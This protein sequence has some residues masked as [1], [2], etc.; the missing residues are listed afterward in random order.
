[1]EKKARIDPN[2]VPNP[3]RPKYYRLPRYFEDRIDAIYCDEFLIPKRYC[4]PKHLEQITTKEAR[5]EGIIFHHA[6]GWVDRFLSRHSL[7][8]RKFHMARRAPVNDSVI[9]HFLNSYETAIHN[10]PDDFIINV[11]ETSWRLLNNR[12]VTITK[13]G[14][15]GVQCFFDGGEKD[16]LTVI[17]G[18]TRSGK[19]L[20]PWV[21]CKG[22]TPRCMNKFLKS[23]ILRQYHQQEALFISFSETGWTTND[24]AIRYLKWLKNEYAKGNPVFLIWDCYASHRSEETK[25]QAQLLHVQLEFVPAGQTGKYQPLD[26]R[27][28]GNLKNK[29]KARFDE[30]DVVNFEISSPTK[31]NWEKS[32]EL[33]LQ[34]WEEIPEEDIINARACIEGIG[35][36]NEAND[37]EQISDVA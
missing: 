29:A 1:M 25:R 17:C 4:T 33:L 30:N 2:Y 18:I 34:C 15:D 31:I 7:S 8:K 35:C 37:D 23:V 21:I 36:L 24:L 19:K 13:R 27:I 5:K 3:R 32:V 12:M 26:F 10:Y 22:K 9:A 14:S 16:C 28:F 20:P 6:R 11:D